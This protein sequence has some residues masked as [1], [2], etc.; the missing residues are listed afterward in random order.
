M[1][2]RFA[3]IWFRHLKTDWIIHRKPELKNIP[4]VLAL[5]DH[6]RMRIT[7]VSAI[8]KSK[9]IFPG[10]V[11]ADARVIIPSLKILD[12]KP[13][14]SDSLLKKLCA[15][16]IRY[17]PVAAID[18]PDGLI[19]DITGCAHLWGGEESYLGNILLRLKTFGFHVR[20]AIADTIGTAWAVCRYAKQKA[21]IKPGKQAEAL[22]QLPPAALRL[23]IDTL[24][25]FQKLGL[26]QVC[27]FITMQRSALRRRFGRQLLLRLDQ[28]LGKEEEFIQPLIPVEPYQERLPCLEPIQTATGI[29]I[30]LQRL[31]GSLCKRLKH[32]GKGLRVAAFK[33]YRIDG[34]TEEIAISTNHP[35]NHSDHIF[36]LFELKIPSIEP[37]FGIE[38][39]TLEASKVESSAP[40]QETLWTPNSS[41]ESKEVS[42]LLDQLENKFG[43]NIIHR[44]LPDEHHL[45]ERSIKLAA[46]LTEKPAIAWRN[47]R[48]RP[49]QLL[50]V[51]HAVEVM[52]PIPDYPPMTFRYKGRLHKVEK[53]DGPERI[54]PEWWIEKGSLRDYYT[55]EDEEGKRFWIFREGQYDAD[56]IPSWFIHGFFA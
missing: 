20:A 7:E 10:M 6:G 2:K 3:A 40:L 13:G 53:A 18:L 41:L 15:W 27:S 17:T 56:K 46:S 14:L 42:E 52:A 8:A 9:E 23:D 50:P 39:F 32:D 30:A 38:L 35:S 25:R 49:I 43:G 54:E 26:Y 4:F 21:I 16:C 48:P 19:L 1:Q 37:A 55:V 36:K 11:V 31:L 45:P 34:K 12:D 22:M 47:D 5:P 24:E 29:E 51:P 33:C 28:A 44:Y